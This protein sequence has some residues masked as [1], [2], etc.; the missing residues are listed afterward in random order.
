LIAAATSRRRPIEANGPG[1][2]SGPIVGSVQAIAVLVATAAAFA[3]LAA[4][5]L[6]RRDVE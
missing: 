4:L 5:V 2:Y 6:R 1:S 3:G